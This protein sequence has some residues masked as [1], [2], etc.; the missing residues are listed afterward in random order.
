MTPVEKL[1]AIQMNSNAPAYQLLTKLLK[2][3]G[4][5]EL[6]EE[7][8]GVRKKC[9]DLMIERETVPWRKPVLKTTH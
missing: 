4:T 3:K 1:K 8:K 7:T 2:E 9:R 5:H 6:K